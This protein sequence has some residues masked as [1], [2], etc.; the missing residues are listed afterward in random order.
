MDLDPVLLARIQFAFTISFHI[1]FPTLTIGLSGFLLI[2]EVLW[3]RTGR[4]VYYRLCRFWA[5]IFAL[6]FGMGVVSGVVL[7]YQFGTNWSVFSTVA[8]NV[9][10]PLLA[11]EVLTAFFMEAGFLG[12]MLFGWE[13]VGRGLHLLSTALVAI[14]TLISSFWILAANSWMHTPAGH[15]VENGIYYMDSFWGVVFNPSFP[16]RLAHMV[17][18]SFLTTA[19]VVAAVSAW[20]MLRGRFTAV[21]RTGMAFG[22]AMA[23]ILAPAQVFVGDLH[24][25]NVLEH[26]PL[27]VAAMEGNWETGPNV[28]L[29]LFAWPDEKAE[30]NRFEIGIPNGASL[31][32]R[33]EAAGVVPGLKDAAPQDRPPVK[34]VFFGF[35]VMVG[36]GLAMIAIAWAASFFLWRRNLERQRWLLWLLLPMGASGFVATLAGWYVAEVGRQPWLIYG[37]FRTAD[38]ISPVVGEAV[39]TSLILFV[40]VYNLLLAAFLW[41]G[42]RLVRRGPDSS[43]APPDLKD[44]LRPLAAPKEA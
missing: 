42:A 39:L 34:P 40:I 14:G 2:L 17:L 31:I 9:L 37:Q 23:A 10:G 24:G 6:A 15:R 7:S 11:Y 5:K 12:I 43:H 25:L 4:E 13:R 32:L 33:H 35:R 18:A 30:K 44:G 19:F 27:K 38:G 26:Q 41:F 20:Y 16:Y 3:L 36:I 22:I 21:A 29:L 1:L 28:P 8:G